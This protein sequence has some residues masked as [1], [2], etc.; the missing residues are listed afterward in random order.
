MKGILKKLMVYSMLGLMQV[1]L[2]AAVA[3]ASPRVEE[4]P[5]VEECCGDPVCMKECVNG[6]TPECKEKHHHKKTI[7][8]AVPQEEN[9]DN[10]I[11]E[12]FQ[13]EYNQSTC[14]K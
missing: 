14:N 7:S 6:V 5:V 10:I 3:S 11:N 13:G 8:Q 1:G 2:F 9:D 12:F 4:T